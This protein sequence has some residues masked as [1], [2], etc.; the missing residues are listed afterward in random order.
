[1]VLFYG[2]QLLIIIF[3]S[4]CRY[5]IRDRK[6]ILVRYN[7]QNTNKILVLTI[8]SYQKCAIVQSCC[9]GRQL[10][11]SLENYPS[12]EKSSI[13]KSLPAANTKLENLNTRVT[14]DPGRC[15]RISIHAQ[16]ISLLFF[17]R[18]HPKS[19]IHLSSF[20]HVL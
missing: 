10:F 14:I 20:F 7:F 6:R 15:R 17:L 3:S 16:M 2:H 13:Q 11:R 12:F 19:S 8:Q 4:R 9:V 5:K 1:M 18:I